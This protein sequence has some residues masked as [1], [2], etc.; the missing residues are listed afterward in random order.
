MRSALIF[1]HIG[2]ELPP[3]LSPV[4]RQ[5]RLFNG[6]PIYLVAEAAALRGPSWPVE[7]GVTPVE[8]EALG[9]S[10]A[11]AEFQRL[12]RF[13]RGFRDGFWSRTTER[14][15]LLE[16]A[17]AQLR[18]GNVVHLENDVMLYADLDE[19]SP[20]LGRLYPG[21]AAT[22]D[23]DERG[24]PGFVFIADLAAISRLT[25]F[26][27]ARFHALNRPATA[28][29]WAHVNDM[30]LLGQFRG[31]GRVAVDHLPI[32]TP[33]YPGTLRS[34]LGH[35]PAD[36]SCYSRHFGELKAVFDAASLGQYL[37][38]VDPRNVPQPTVGFINES[39]VFDPRRSGIRML[40]DE[41][42][43]KVPRIET[44]SGL[45]RVANLHIH[46][47]ATAAFSSG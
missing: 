34:R 31:E 28:Q 46:C 11:H 36:P 22:F 21:I 43:R 29:R 16:S 33:D 14:F 4:L 10:T 6:C 20:A 32:V 39:C 24:V 26:I 8:V 44:A 23:N 41:A 5:A 25:A 2:A 13:D 40:R 45:H 3:W 19:M 37:G 42:G 47:K 1:V 9:H 7:L 35:V 17:M 27:I 38:G 18:L 15:F 12:S 30:W